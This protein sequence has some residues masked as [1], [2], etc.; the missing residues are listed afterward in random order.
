MVDLNMSALSILLF[1]YFTMLI[2]IKD[3]K[4]K[5]IFG[6]NIKKPRMILHSSATYIIS[7]ILQI[8]RGLRMIYIYLNC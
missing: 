7:S 3:D 5:S 4:D 8:L 6:L 1:W 2:L